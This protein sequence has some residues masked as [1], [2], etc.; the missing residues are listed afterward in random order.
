MVKKFLVKKASFDFS[1]EL[2]FCIDP[3]ILDD[4][5]KIKYSQSQNPHVFL[6]FKPVTLITRKYIHL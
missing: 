1:L 3:N 5:S 4:D 6:S 2:Y